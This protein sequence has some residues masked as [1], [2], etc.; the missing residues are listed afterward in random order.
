MET[1]LKS[2]F[3]RIHWSLALKAAI[4][5]L[6]WFF[7]PFWA[8]LL[9]ALYFYFSP[10]FRPLT[11]ALPFSLLILFAAAEPK[12]VPLAVFFAVLF[13]LILG[14]K[15]LI[16]I[17]RKESYE[18]LVLLLSFLMF[19]TFFV[20]LDGGIDLRAL[21]Y[22]LATVTA[23]VF[24]ALCFL[25]YDLGFEEKNVRRRRNIALGLTGILLWQISLA[26]LF[27]PINFLYQAA[28][29]FLAAAMALTLMADYFA[30]R[31]S[32]QRILVDFSIA[33]VVLVFIL[34][35]A[36]WGL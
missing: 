33:L 15:D 25:R 34:G 22:S 12:G 28:I 21:P 29:L 17:N 4:F 18:A 7:L 14:I 26:A 23:F 5:S 19:V 6:G 8:F 16:L 13:Y 1:K 11:L 27:L 24:L 32:R 30:N 10:L 36:S 3:G 35:S 9:I 2:I 20:R 31:L